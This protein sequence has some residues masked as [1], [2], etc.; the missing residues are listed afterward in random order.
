MALTVS[1][2]GADKEVFWNFYET[3]FIRERATQEMLCT[4]VIN[5]PHGLL[6]SH[7]YRRGAE[8]VVYMFP[9]RS[10]PPSGA[11]P[12]RW[13][14]RVTPLLAEYEDEPWAVK[15]NYV[16]ATQ[17]FHVTTWSTKKA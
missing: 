12:P 10:S 13:G 15:I 17:C 8:V 9:T 4:A 5:D 3:F 2:P 14:V 7:I 6:F 11:R 16:A 1:C